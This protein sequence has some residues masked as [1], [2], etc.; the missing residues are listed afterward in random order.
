VGDYLIGSHIGSRTTFPLGSYYEND[1]RHE[2]ALYLAINAFVL[3]LFLLLVKPFIKKEGLMSY[4]FVVWYAI[5]RFLIDFTR[6]SDIDMLAEPRYAHLTLTQ[7]A[8]IGLF[9]IFVPL[10]SLKIAKRK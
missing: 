8:C 6:N 2:P 5:A 10:L 7:W 1:L 9:V 4:I 3:F